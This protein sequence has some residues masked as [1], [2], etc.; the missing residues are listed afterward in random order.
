VSWRRYCGIGYSGGNGLGAHVT[1]IRLRV[2][3]RPVIATE[4]L[5]R[6]AAARV[7]RRA[8]DEKADSM[9]SNA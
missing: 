6:N 3:R 7:S 2:R 8:V 5:F 4:A 9:S 1:S